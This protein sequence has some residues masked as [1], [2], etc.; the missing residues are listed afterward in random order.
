M[1]ETSLLGIPF[2]GGVENTVYYDSHTDKVYKV[3]N[4]ITSRSIGNFICRMLQHNALFPQTAYELVGFTGFGKSS[5]Y[6]IVCQ[7]Y[8][9][10]ATYATHG[11]ILDY[12]ESLGFQT[13]GDATFTN[14][15]I[16]INDLRPRN[17]LKTPN[18][19]LFVID[20]DFKF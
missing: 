16:I 1:E 2:P 8:I 17:V 5:V 3:N 15:S 11:E 19:A 9:P 12:M 4:L 7:D 10:N 18:G 14:G 6:P 13:C 20:A